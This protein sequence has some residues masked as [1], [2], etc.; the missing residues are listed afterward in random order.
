[1]DV[2]LA[3]LA[4]AAVLC[5]L[6]PAPATA[7]AAEPLPGSTTPSPAPP[8]F[9]PPKPEGYEVASRVAIRIADKDPKVAEQSER[10][11][12]LTTAIQTTD[13]GAWQVGYKSGADEVAQVKVD[14]VSGQIR[15]SWT[16]YQVAWPMAR[17]YGGQFGHVLN[18]PYVWIPL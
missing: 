13:D 15:E 17:G 12:Q 3:A 4:G 2:R 18:A 8:D 10:Y 5:L 14:G 7:V 6:A 9:F 11:G 1:M 16:G